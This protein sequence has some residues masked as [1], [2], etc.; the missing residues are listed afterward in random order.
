MVRH[1]RKRMSE[2]TP[3]AEVY[4]PMTKYFIKHPRTPTPHPKLPLDMQV[5]AKD[6]VILFISQTCVICS[7]QKTPRPLRRVPEI[8]AAQQTS[9]STQ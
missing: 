7:H 5:Y 6:S 2:K 8:F 1:F 9:L 4:P 3:Y